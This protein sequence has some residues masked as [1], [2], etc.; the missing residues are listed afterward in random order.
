MASEEFGNGNPQD[1]ELP[2]FEDLEDDND[3]LILE[4]WN[5]G[6]ET[7][8]GT[9]GHWVDRSQDLA[10][11]ACQNCGM[12]FRTPPLEHRKFDKMLWRPED[13]P[14]A[15]LSEDEVKRRLPAVTRICD[16][17]IRSEVIRLSSEAPAYFWNV[18]AASPTSDYHHPVCREH[19]GLWAHTLMLIEPLCRLE[20]S[21]RAQGRLAD[22]ERDYAIAAALLHDQRK[23]GPHGTDET[24]STSDHDVEMARVIEEESELPQPVADAV[25]SHM[26]PWY[27]GPEPETPLQD[28]VHTA[29]M[30]ASTATVTPTI[31]SPIPEELA[32]LGLE[33]SD[34]A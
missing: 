7:P 24:S 2:E 20:E 25:A 30:M 15:T 11:E 10:S 18:P 5:C 14:R 16:K 4:C 1:D 28:L 12:E 21:Y 3:P 6:A 34:S 26:G 19:H 8:S 13:Y 29:D 22:E 32:E 27:D 31:P 17:S 9:L 33:E 23:R